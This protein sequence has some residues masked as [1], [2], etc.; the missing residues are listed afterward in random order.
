MK[1]LMYAFLISTLCLFGTLGPLVLSAQ[2][3]KTKVAFAGRQAEWHGFTIYTH[4]GRKVVLPKQAA[5][6]RPWVLRARFWGHEPQFDIA[7]LNKGYHL[8]YCNIG[9]LFGNPEAVARWDAFYTELTQKHGFSSKVVLEGFS[10][11]GLVVY[12]WACA[13]TGKVAAIYGDAAVMDMKSWPGVSHAGMRR[14]YHFQT[15][16]DVR[17][18]TGNPIDNLAPL[19]KAGIPIIH[20]VGDADETVPVLENSGLAQ[21]RYRESGGVFD[22]IH[23]PDCRHHPHSLKDPAPLVAFIEK[24]VE[25]K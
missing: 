4:Q 17:A 24:Y 5:P 11:G 15:E 20:V 16:D 8:A 22:L 25:S 1:R 12:N 21:K 2:T 13:N 7:M 14:A 10:R 19:A 3:N 23:K 6:G 9:G 18:F